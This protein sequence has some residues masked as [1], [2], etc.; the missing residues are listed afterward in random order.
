MLGNIDNSEFIHKIVAAEKNSKL[1]LKPRKILLINELCP[2]DLLMLTAAIRD[3]KICHPEISVEVKTVCPAIWENNPDITQF[4]KDD[5]EVE[6]FKIGYPLI[7]SSNNGQYHFIHGFRKDIED[8]LGI[9][10][11]PTKF[12]GAIYLSEE[13]KSWLSQ[14]EEM[15][16]KDKFWIMVAG[17]KYD[18]TA[19]WWNPDSYQQVVNH[20]KGK[21]TFA[22]CGEEG[23]WHPP[24]KNVVNLIGKTNLRQFIRLIYHSIGVLCPV[25]FAMHAAAAI[26]CKYNL[27]NRPCVVIAG[28][29]EPS[30]WEKYPHHRFLENNGCLPCCDNGGCWKSRCQKVGDGDEKDTEG[31]CLF[32]IKIK[33]DLLIPKCLDMIKPTDVIR[34]IEMYYNGGVLQY[35]E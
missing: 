15:G 18:Y 8:K 14:I 22:Q 13:E 11:T 23:H 7:H 32:P 26:D 35:N 21:I 1:D 33:E 29:R 12:K 10:I 4:E 24:L 2:G 28:G 17:G 30:Q 5:P 3:L 16:I 9:T 20:F 34:A 19:K 31:V 25:T 6:E 27:R